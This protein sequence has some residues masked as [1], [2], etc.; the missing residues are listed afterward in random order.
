MEAF[1]RSQVLASVLSGSELMALRTGELRRAEK[2]NE[3]EEKIKIV[4]MGT[5]KTKNKK[6]I[7]VLRTGELRRGKKNEGEEENEIVTRKR[8]NRDS[9][10]ENWVKTE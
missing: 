7:M 8:G 3:G 2:K 6:K 4:K 5:E 1:K 9:K 10:N